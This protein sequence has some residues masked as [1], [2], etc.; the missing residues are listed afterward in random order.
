MPRT[1]AVA[2]ALALLVGAGP[3]RTAEL[4]PE[5][6]SFTADGVVQIGDDRLSFDVYHRG[7]KERQEM[8]IDGLFQ[9]T[10]LRPDLGAAYLVQ[11]AADAF[12]PLR[13]DEVGLWPRYRGGVGY[14]VELKGKER[15]AGEDTSLYHVTSQAGAAVEMDILVWITEDGIEMRLEGEMEVEGMMES[16]VLERSNIRRAPLDDAL[17]DPAVALAADDPKLEVPDS[18]EEVGT[19]GP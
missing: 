11:P 5:T 19:V 2:L 10:I 15:V 18:H 12:I 8:T 13:L 1:I 6:A 4:P 16:V 9:I 3:G 17:F 7:G 14:K